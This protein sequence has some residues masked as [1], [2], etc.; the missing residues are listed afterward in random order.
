MRELEKLAQ[1]KRETVSAIVALATAY[2][3]LWQTVDQNPQD[4]QFVAAMLG[5]LHGSS[6]IPRMEAL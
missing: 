6:V 2:E 3:T 4:A 5:Y 1:T